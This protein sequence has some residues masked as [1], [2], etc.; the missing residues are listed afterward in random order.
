M[1]LH[2]AVLLRIATR[3]SQGLRQLQDHCKGR[4]STVGKAESAEWL[5]GRSH[6]GLGEV[7]DN[8]QKWLW[9]LNEVEGR[10]V[11]RAMLRSRVQPAGHPVNKCIH[12]VGITQ[13]GCG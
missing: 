8:K 6:L 1:Q 13:R 4:E 2:G 3:D 7:G 11:G 10:A 12:Y 5:K 9:I